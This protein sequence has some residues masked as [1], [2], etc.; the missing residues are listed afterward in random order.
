MKQVEKPET[1]TGLESQPSDS[2]PSTLGR[3]HFIQT[4]GVALAA[5]GLNGL[6]QAQTAPQSDLVQ[7]S[8]I[9]DTSTEAP[10]KAP[11]P[12]TAPDERVGFAIVG[13]GRLSI[14]QILPAFGKSKYCK[15]VALVSGDRAKA[16]KIAAQYGIKTSSVYDYAGYDRLKDNPEVKVIYIVLPN[17]MHLEYVLRGAEGRASR[18]SAR[19]RWPLS[20]AEAGEDDRRLQNREREADDRVPATVRA[21][22]SARSSRW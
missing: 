9:H 17:S 8:Q 12:F 1:A 20:S 3:R 19:S 11:G 18:S 13:L 10:E 16:L 6:A 4:A 7:L 22:E 15:P 21:H 2:S 5:A 14:D